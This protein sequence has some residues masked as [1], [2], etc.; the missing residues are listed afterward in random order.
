MDDDGNAIIDAADPICDRCKE[1]E[2][3]PLH[4]LSDCD[5]LATLR[6][7][8][9]G[10]HNLVEPGETPDFSEWPAYKLIAFFREAKFKALTMLP[11]QAQYLPTNTSNEE[12][13]ES[14]RAEKEAAD[15]QGTKWTSR[16]LFHIPLKVGHKPRQ[17]DDSQSDS[18]STSSSQ[19][20]THSNTTLAG[21]SLGQ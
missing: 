13:N 2:E 1:G 10:K 20:N 19:T 9:F 3:T 12:S 18:A 7:Q 17:L 8:I 14:L 4:L 11:F 5:P 21:R 16:Y 15:E 6:M